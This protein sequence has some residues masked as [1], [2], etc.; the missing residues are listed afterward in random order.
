MKFDSG[1]DRIWGNMSQETKENSNEAVVVNFQKMK[2]ELD[3]WE[4]NKTL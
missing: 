3:S 1:V 2:K 4:R